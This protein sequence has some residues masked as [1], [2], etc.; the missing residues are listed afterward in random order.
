MIKE[1]LDTA[2]IKRYI[3]LNNDYSLEDPY[4][5][6]K[7]EREFLKENK[8][9]LRSKKLLIFVLTYQQKD[10]GFIKLSC[11]DKTIYIEELFI[12]QSYRKLKTYKELL[13]IK[14]LIDDYNYYNL[15]KYVGVNDKKN[16]IN[17]FYNFNY[18]MEKEHIQMEKRIYNKYDINFKIEKKSF[19][20]LKNSKWI[21]NFMKESMS[22]K[23]INYKYKEIEELTE[24]I[25]DL[26]FVFYKDG[27]P[28][29]F[30]VSLINKQRNKQQKQKVI[31]IEELAVHEKF[32]NS[33]YGKQILK[34]VIN[35]GKDKGMNLARLHVYK[36]N[37]VAY[38]LYQ[39]LG[40]NEVKSIG[41]WVCKKAK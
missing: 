9:K 34:F 13:D 3:K 25:D 39:N 31:Y 24:K 35:K 6:K 37:W 20:D 23:S 33:G 40:F 38:K 17:A 5:L 1:Q 26:C 11:N 16:L 8:S 22:T 14:D 21:Y 2:N 10:V 4:I 29:G 12:K 19:S 32:R 18:Y 30:V 7:T 28:L 41:H 15:I 36:D 27:I